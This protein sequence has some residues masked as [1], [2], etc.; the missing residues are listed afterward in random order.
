MALIISTEALS[1]DA[2]LTKRG[3]ELLSSG[4]G[5]F[6]I[7]KFAVSDDE[8]N[9]ALSEAVI[10]ALPLREA[11]INGDVELRYKLIS[12]TN[13]NTLVMAQIINVNFATAN[14]MSNGSLIIEPGTSNGGDTEAGYSITIAN[15][16]D[17]T[18]P[19]ATITVLE[20]TNSSFSNSDYSATGKKFKIIAKEITTSKSVDVR[21]VGR[22]TGAFTTFTIDIDPNPATQ[23]QSI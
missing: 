11:S 12:N 14:M 22:E 7:T 20:S 16:S 4:N 15:T 5:K 23:Q 2:T 8:I 17:S 3:R 6:N 9:Y 1:I 10:E 19:S 21:I 18:L 13:P